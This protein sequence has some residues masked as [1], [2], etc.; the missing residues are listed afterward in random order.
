LLRQLAP[1]APES[2]DLRQS[3]QTAWLLWRLEKTEARKWVERSR[4]LVGA[5]QGPWAEGVEAMLEDFSGEWE[6]SMLDYLELEKPVG[7]ALAAVYLGD[8]M[9]GRGKLDE[10]LTR[11][12][13]AGK[14]WAAMPERENA[15]ALTLFLQARVYWE[16]RDLAAVRYALEQAQEAL[17]AC[18]PGLQAN[19][20]NAMQKA[21]KLLAAGRIRK[22]PVC[23]W[24]AYDDEFRILL[25]FR[26]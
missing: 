17:P 10:A 13:Q 20:Q 25:L 5:L 9:L 3:V 2:E 19:L 18:P 12:Q 8:Q 16:M 15:S 24:Q 1:T 23:D 11:Y 21:N 14:L 6:F 7:A 26:P 4:E 22:W